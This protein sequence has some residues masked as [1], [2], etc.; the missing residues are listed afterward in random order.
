MKL[1]SERTWSVCKVGARFEGLELRKSWKLGLV[2]SS[3]DTVAI[4]PTVCSLRHPFFFVLPVLPGISAW[5]SCRRNKNKNAEVSWFEKGKRADGGV[6]WRG[7]G[8]E[9]W[10]SAQSDNWG[11][12]F[13][14]PWR[15]KKVSRAMHGH[16]LAS[17]ESICM[18]GVWMG[19]VEN[20]YTK[21]MQTS[22]TTK[23]L[24]PLN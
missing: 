21:A 6:E 12:I 19:N 23:Y 24:N 14:P 7:R 5:A 10:E 16:W 18:E 1:V 17:G 2:F 8:Y 13:S 15:T 11:I 3:L 22:R 20:E 4:H 9:G